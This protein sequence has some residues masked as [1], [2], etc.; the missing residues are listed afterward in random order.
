MK[1]AQI[2][3]LYESVPPRLY[4]GTERVVHYIT[5]ELVAQ[6]HEVTLYA[7]GDSVTNAELIPCCKAALRLSKSTI[8]PLAPHFQMMELV[9]KDAHK[10]D[11]I[12]S[13]IDYL[14]YPLIKRTSYNFLSTLH[15][16]LDIPEL[17]PL[18]HEYFQIPVVSI[19]NSQRLPLPHANWQGTVYHGLPLN[20]YAPIEKPG[21]YLAFIG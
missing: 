11:I 3:P 12:H 8:D 16:R 17:G 2:A 20:L 18:Y 1:I 10:Y 19:S 4:G 7:S 13:H 9:A 21:T 5:E 14:I 15:G 6:G